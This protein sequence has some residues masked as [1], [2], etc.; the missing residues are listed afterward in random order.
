[1]LFKGN[2]NEPVAYKVLSRGYIYASE[3]AVSFSFVTALLNPN[4]NLI[5]KLCKKNSRLP[6]WLLVKQKLC[7]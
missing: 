6:F 7:N 2:K 1:M 3:L 4:E 5:L